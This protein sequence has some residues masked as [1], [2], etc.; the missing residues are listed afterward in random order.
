MWQGLRNKT[1]CFHFL[2][3]F[4]PTVTFTRCEE[5]LK[6][7]RRP[8]PHS[9]GECHAFPSFHGR[10]LNR[11]FVAYVGYANRRQV[12][13]SRPKVCCHWRLLLPS[14]FADLFL[15]PRG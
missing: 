6:N 1:G 13:P 14:L 10:H 9:K 11:R 2:S 8:R 15:R 12:L 7:A 4:R 5:C 3:F